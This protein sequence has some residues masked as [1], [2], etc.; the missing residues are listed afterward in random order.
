[1]THAEVQALIKLWE[2]TLAEQ[3]A[4][5]EWKKKAVPAPNVPLSFS[6]ALRLSR[7]PLSDGLAKLLH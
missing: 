2:K 5:Y 3:R 7:A 1:M 4:K 6:H